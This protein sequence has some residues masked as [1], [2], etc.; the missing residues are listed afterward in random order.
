[1]ESLSAEDVQGEIARNIRKG[2]NIM[3]DEYSGYRGLDEKFNHHT[4]NHSAGEYVRH[5]FCHVNGIEGAWSLFKRQ[6]FGIHHF[7][8]TKCPPSALVGQ[9]G[10]L[11]E[12]RLSGS[13]YLTAEAQMRQKSAT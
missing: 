8:S 12:G 13:S 7:V 6:I 4:V 9:N 1:M 3:T 5:Y 11:E 10:R 2:S